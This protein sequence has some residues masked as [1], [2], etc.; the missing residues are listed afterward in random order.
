MSEITRICARCG[1][2][3]PLDA[4]FCPH[5]GYDVDAELP[6]PAGRNLPVALGRAALPI[7]AGVAGL[8]A[9]AAWRFLQGRMEQAI[10]PTPQSQ[11]PAVQ[12]APP[13]ATRARRTIHIRTAWAVGDARGIWRQGQS[14]QT[15][16]IEE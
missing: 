14:D 15:I 13:A 6:T 1:Q 16:E 4:R 12:P 5:C 10:A 2:S 3:G 8:A 9:R 11:P 7:L